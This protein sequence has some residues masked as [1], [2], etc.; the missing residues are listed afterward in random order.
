MLGFIRQLFSPNQSTSTATKKFLILVWA[1]IGLGFWILQPSPL[2]PGPGAVLNALLELWSN[3]LAAHLLVS[4]QLNL[5]ALG[6]STALS[7]GLAYATV[8]PVFKPP[9]AFVAKLRFLGLTGL[10][11][12]FGLYLAGHQLKVGLLVLGMTVFFTTS[13]MAVVAAI[14]RER[15]DHARTLGMSEWRVVW[16]VVILGTID[17]ALEIL[18]QNAAV[19]W[20]MLTMVEGLVRSEGG[21]GAML[22]NENRHFKLEAVFALQL[23][24]L[25]IGLLQDWGLGLVRKMICPYADLAVERK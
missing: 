9:V 24:I 17:Q 2:L 8:L 23:T 4:L 7:L 5:E 12:L 3:G 20:L 19:G 10:T 18:K 14:P 15:L 6:I 1:A 21:M 22:L 11:F 25:V 16:E 13:M